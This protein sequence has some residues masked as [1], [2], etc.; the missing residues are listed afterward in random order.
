MADSNNLGFPW[1]GLAVLVA[2][3]T[4][5]QLVP[6]AFEQLRPPEKERSQPSL[7]AELEVDARLWEDP[8]AAM[9]R[10]EAERCEKLRKANS[11]ADCSPDKAQM[12]GPELLRKKLDRDGDKDWSNSM[13][14]LA[15]VPGN[16]F[17]GAEEARRRTRYAILAGLQAQGY[18][19]DNAERIGLLEFKLDDL[20]AS[21]QE[22]PVA[23]PLA[24]KSDEKKVT[25]LDEKKP[26]FV[27]PFEMLSVRHL[28]RENDNERKNK[29]EKRLYQQVA[30]LWVDE[31]ALPPSK[32]TSLARMVD[33]MFGPYRVANSL[34]DDARKLADVEK[35]SESIQENTP[36]DSANEKNPFKVCIKNDNQENDKGTSA[37]IKKFSLKDDVF[38][39]E[40]L[41]STKQV[42]RLVVIGPSSTD[43]L[44]RA[45]TELRLA[46]DK[47]S[48]EGN[49]KP[50]EYCE[51]LDVAN[52]E[53]HKNTEANKIAEL[54]K[55]ADRSAVDGYRLLAKAELIDASATAPSKM[56]DELKKQDL[57]A[58]LNEKFEHMLGGK[59][60]PKIDFRR[61]ITTDDELI[62]NLVTELKMRLP[63]KSGRRIVV[64]AER[65]SLYSQSLVSELEYRLRDSRHLKFEEVYF[66]R[67]LDG[68]TTR[69]AM[70]DDRDK[71]TGKANAPEVQLEWPESRDQLD[72]L[73]RLA[74]SLKQSEAAAELGPIGAIGILGNDVHDKLLV[75][76]ALHDTFSD[77]VFFTTDMDARYLHPQTQTFTRNLIVASSL[78]LAFYP[79]VGADT[80]DLQAG[81]PPL[82]DVYQSAN[83]L[84][85]R[86]AGCRSSACKESEQDAADTALKHPSVYEV[87]R[88]NAV[89][90]AGYALTMLPEQSLMPRMLVASSIALLMLLG[91]FVW[92]S[93][94][95][96][97][98]AR[99]LCLKLPMPPDTSRMTMPSEVLI[100][101]HAALCAFVL[102]SLVEFVYPNRISFVQTLM[103][104]MLS[105]IAVLLVILPKRRNLPEPRDVLESSIGHLGVGILILVLAVWAWLAWP[106]SLRP[107]CLNCEPVTWLEGV[108]AWPSHL[109]HLLA[110]MTILC[111]LDIA[112]CDMLRLQFK[113]SKWMALDLSL[114]RPLN[115]SSM[116]N[117]WRDWFSRISIFSWR[118]KLGSSNDFQTL[119]LAYIE[120][121]ESLPRAARTVFSYLC[122][123]LLVSLLFFG[124]SEGQ[125]PEVPVRGTDHRYLVRAT[126]YVILLLLPLLIVAVADA[127]LLA[128][129][130]ISHLNCGRSIYPIRTIQHFADALGE[131]HAQLWQ[132][133]FAAEPSARHL[134]A[135]KQLLIPPKGDDSASVEHS[136]LDDWLDVQVVARRT[137]YVSRLVIGPFAVLALLVI[138][139]SRLFDNWSLT[140]AIAIAISVYLVWLVLL[141][142]LLKLAAEKAKRRALI[143]MNADLR[144]LEGSGTEMA[145]LV[146]P[147]KRLIV[148][149]ETNQTGAFVPLF[150]QP[151]LRALLVP[152]GGAGG[153]HLFDLLLGH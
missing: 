120:R 147:F 22:T 77:K 91:L 11:T 14:L 27:V 42:P 31:S 87:G 45:L 80:I 114:T 59:P 124:L 25:F 105:A 116:K 35:K 98:H 16:P 118:R 136:L 133:R 85:A 69:D 109:L 103:L 150:E 63:T 68:V 102:C 128:L 60:P 6:H 129:R 17:V 71:N 151:L 99:R 24:S 73:R 143:S 142:L 15:L 12:R 112:W 20:T 125:V 146:D 127:T 33:A 110:L 92:P 67:G 3:V 134:D 26:T 122:T 44:R 74:I 5:T 139:R 51:F 72:Y 39:R 94:P 96:I 82:R 54:R 126:L 148:S 58:F 28:H 30:L 123:I 79:P 13:V 106:G 21:D 40:N 37:V 23:V 100:A 138:A 78:P 1:A 43:A 66:F 76:Q 97:R 55:I 56:L 52:G 131:Q 84:A 152:L 8:F 149:V 19:P 61:T 101:L 119:W 18:V 153:A 111:L 141:A 2:F 57:E 64:V 113:D 107:I 108:S 145:K 137:E 10:Y 9:R 38:T 50:M 48:V 4:S 81:T 93:T 46:S 135:S 117:L 121:G 88:K 89:P 132:R 36:L 41:Q 29:E 49:K 86:Y 62:K 53:P 140:P 75:M 95:S 7:S 32:L 65:D 34:I 47:F 115:R 104:T 70:R 144:W 130:F 83:Y 90:L